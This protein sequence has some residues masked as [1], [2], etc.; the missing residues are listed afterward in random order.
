MVARL[1]SRFELLGRLQRGASARHA[2]LLA[3]LEGTWSELSTDEKLLLAQLA[4]FPGVFELDSVEAVA[5][6]L[7]LATPARGLTRLVDFGVLFTDGVHYRLLETIKLFVRQH[8]DHER[9]DRLHADWCLRRAT[10]ESWAAQLLS[11]DLLRWVGTHHDDLVAAE[12]HF[13]RTG[14]YHAVAALLGAQC[15]AL[16]AAL[17][18]AKATG[19][20]ARIEQHLRSTALSTRDR[21]MLNLVAAFAGRPARRPDWYVKGAR[22]AAALFAACGDEVGLAMALIVLSW[23]TALRDTD[24]ALDLVDRAIEAAE[25]AEEASLAR[26]ARTNRV[27]PLLAALRFAEAAAELDRVRPLLAASP[28][29]MTSVLFATYQCMNDSFFDPARA[30]RNV[31]LLYERQSAMSASPDNTLMV[32]AVAAASAG[33]IAWTHRLVEQCVEQF[34]PGDSDDGLPDLLVPLAM[35]AWRLDDEERARRLLTA[36]W[37]AGRPTSNVASTIAY[38]GLRQFIA[39]DPERP[40]DLDLS[41]EFGGARTWLRELDGEDIDAR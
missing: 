6:A 37:H 35:L 13:R 40:A 2:S 7:A 25:R 3:V 1:D 4:A 9:H 38:R 23:M 8:T 29:D 14:D 12:H 36:V 30:G 16:N 32:F 19:T 27:V 33:D 5:S 10:A 21:A 11:W 39:I 24:G 15:N 34:R 20:I 17:G 18:G 41:A 22:E 31:P 28:E 26:F